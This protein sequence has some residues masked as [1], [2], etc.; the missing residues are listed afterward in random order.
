MIWEQDDACP[1]EGRVLEG[2][3]LPYRTITKHK[4]FARAASI[5]EQ[6]SLVKLMHAFLQVCELGSMRSAERKQK[7]KKQQQKKPNTTENLWSS[8]TGNS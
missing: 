1:E 3:E 4:P 6:R 2:Y 5:L 7:T 8:I